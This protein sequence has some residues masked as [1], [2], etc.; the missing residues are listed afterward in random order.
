MQLTT[1]PWPD[2]S[3]SFPVPLSLMPVRSPRR[4]RPGVCAQA[5]GSA[6][7]QSSSGTWS[8]R[9]GIVL[10]VPNPTHRTE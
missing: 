6:H 7:Q 3:S 4:I 2:Q 8:Y 5:V 10:E 1:C 9:R